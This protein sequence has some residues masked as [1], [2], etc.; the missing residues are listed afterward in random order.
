M[1]AVETA[2]A[3]KIYPMDNYDGGRAASEPEHY[4]LTELGFIAQART[5]PD[6]DDV[7]TLS[8]AVIALTRFE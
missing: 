8:L 2:A 3:R 6:D 1:Q 7:R 4:R 5:E